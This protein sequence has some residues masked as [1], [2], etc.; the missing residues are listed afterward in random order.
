MTLLAEIQAGGFNLVNRDDG[1]IATALSIGRKKIVTTLG[2]I[3]TVLEALGPVDGAALLDQL[4]P[5]SNS[6][7]LISTNAHF[8][9][10]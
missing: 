1:V 2:G 6:P 9:A 5:K 7:R 8:T 10:G 3:G 4:E